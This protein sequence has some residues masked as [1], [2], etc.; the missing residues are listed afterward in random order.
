MAPAAFYRIGAPGI[1]SKKSLQRA[2][3]YLLAAMLSLTLALALDAYVVTLVALANIG[4]GVLLAIAVA[5]LCVLNW[6]ILPARDKQNMA[7]Y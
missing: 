7:P 4:A 5:V 6:F 3:R 1:V 2:S